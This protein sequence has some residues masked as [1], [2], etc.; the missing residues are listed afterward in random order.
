MKIGIDIDD[1]LTCTFEY[2]I[3]HVRD[4]MENVLHKQ[5]KYIESEQEWH[6]LREHLEL[7][8]QEEKYCLNNF[9]GNRD[10]YL[11]IEGAVEFVKN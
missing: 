8:E 3:S 6:H 5:Y 11:P 4:Y 10:K 2:I 9:F 7:S 1:T